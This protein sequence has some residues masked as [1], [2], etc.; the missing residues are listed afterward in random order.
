MD[1]SILNS[2]LELIQ[3]LST[4]EDKAIIDKL[5]RFRDEEN[6]DWW[7]STSLEAKVSIE[8]G[9]T[10]AENGKLS[11]HSEARKLYEKWL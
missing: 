1:S 3:W 10:D 6:K 8:K 4:I 5:L 7:N 2:K 11:S 9:I